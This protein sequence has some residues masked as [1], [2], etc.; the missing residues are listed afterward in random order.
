MTKVSKAIAIPAAAYLAVCAAMFACSENAVD[1]GDETEDTTA[2]VTSLLS[3]M[4]AG[5]SAASSAASSG[6]T[7]GASAPAGDG[8]TQNANA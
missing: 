8:T 2:D 1:P 7:S 4:D 5:S 6:G 3:A